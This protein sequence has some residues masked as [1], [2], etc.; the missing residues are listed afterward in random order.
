MIWDR[1]L[2][3][4]RSNWALLRAAT[5]DVGAEVE[6]WAYAE[7]DRDAEEQ[8]PIERR[9]AGRPVVFTIERIG[10]RRDGDLHLCID[11]RGGPRTL[12]GVKPSYVFFKRPDG[13]VHYGT[14]VGARAT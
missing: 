1:W 8:A 12:L 9:V 2:R 5:D 13:T 14:P 10:R 11:A 4:Y 7:L 6:R 3:P